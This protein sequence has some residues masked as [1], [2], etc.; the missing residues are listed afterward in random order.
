AESAWTGACFVFDK[1]V[2]VTHGLEEGPHTLC[3]GCRR[4]LNP[5][6]LLRAEYEAGVSCHRCADEYDEA[7]RA[8]FR[9]RRRQLAIG[10][11]D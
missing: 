8:R 1:R 4:P 2:S 9:E 7:D 3:H 6:D 10:G 11:H 5:S